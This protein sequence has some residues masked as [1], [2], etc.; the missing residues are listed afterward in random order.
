MFQLKRVY[1]APARVDGKRF[2]IERLW[3][4]GIKKEESENRRLAQRGW[5]QH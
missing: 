1:D 2:L 3:P 4:R 5:T